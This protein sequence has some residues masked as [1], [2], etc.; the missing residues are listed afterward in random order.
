MKGPAEGPWTDSTFSVKKPCG[1]ER[2]E[3]KARLRRLTVCVSAWRTRI[4]KVKSLLD[5]IAVSVFL[6]LSPSHAQTQTHTFGLCKE[7]SAQQLKKA[8]S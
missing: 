2:A 7:F 6:E 1:T 4:K 8:S 5:L 3:G